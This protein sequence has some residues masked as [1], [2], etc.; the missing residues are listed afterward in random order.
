MNS[1][2]IIARIVCICLV[3]LAVSC[4]PK[5]GMENV[6]KEDIT[7]AANLAL[8]EKV[9]ASASASVNDDY[10]ANKV[11]D[12]SVYTKWMDS[13]SKD[14]WLMY[15]LGAYCNINSYTIHWDAERSASTY[16]I[17]KSEDGINWTD[18]TSAK[19]RTP[20]IT[21]KLSIP[22]VRYVRLFI[23]AE[24]AGAVGV[25]E[26][27]V[28]GIVSKPLQ[29][30]LSFS[31]EFN[32]SGLPD[33][34]KW[35]IPEYNRRNN[36]DGPDGLWKRGYAYQENG[37]LVIKVDRIPNSNNDKDPYDYAVGAI[38]TANKFTQRFGKFEMRA[39]LPQ[40]QGWWVA[41][42]MMQ[43]HQGSIGNGGVDGSEVDIMEA[44]GWTDRI[45]HAIHWD[46]Y[47]A[48]HKEVSATEKVQGIREGYHTYTL[49]W[50]PDRYEI[51]IDGVLKW[52]TTG[53]GVCLHPGY[54]KVTGEIS[55]LPWA[56]NNLWSLDPGGVEYPD[57]FLV[58]YVR[59]YTQN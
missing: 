55:T 38:R 18:V 2:F 7:L 30:T 14:K 41:F 21:Q 28:R 47:E 19:V 12:N 10:A 58:D 1:S 52:R 3:L 56:T 22:D 5:Y 59:V 29:W 9:F 4:S 36:P 16:K 35:D 17:Q 43:G 49:E 54:I 48:H 44:W 57:Y 34:S 11:R 46:G 33:E 27:E 26:F 13:T 39:K 23:P 45:N 6:K 15:D 8:N 40:K 24:A 31:D 37:N 32:G 42:W 51:F 53:G 25:A 50:Y 20:I